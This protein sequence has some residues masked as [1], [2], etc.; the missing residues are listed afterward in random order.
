[1]GKNSAIEWTHHTFNPWWGC[2]KISP[3]CHNCYAEKWSKRLGSKVWGSS[4]ERRF[5][6]EKHWRE[7]LLW[8]KKAEKNTNTVLNFV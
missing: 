2:T 6:G 5:F 7:P 1:M 8:N 4:A 3:A